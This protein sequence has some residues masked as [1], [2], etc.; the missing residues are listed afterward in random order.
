MEENYRIQGSMVVSVTLLNPTEL[1]R[2]LPSV[3]TSG[4]DLAVLSHQDGWIDPHAALMGF[5][6]KAVASGVTY[7]EAEVIRLE[8]AGN[9]VGRAYGKHGTTFEADLFIN[10]SGAWCAELA[11]TVDLELPVEPMS[12]ESYFFRCGEAVEPLPFIKTETDLAF[13]PER[14]GYVGGVPDLSE[15]PGWNF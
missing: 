11:Q 6:R 10:A 9:A 13:R 7:K 8:K 3:K 4:V 14:Q 12:R 5:P 2:R 1:L 15:K